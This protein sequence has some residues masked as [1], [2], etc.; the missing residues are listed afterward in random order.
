MHATTLFA[1]GLDWLEGL[2]PFLF[3]LFWIVSQVV[4]V[5]KG[6]AGRGKQPPVVARPAK[7]P[8]PQ[9]AGRDVRGE[10]ERQIEEFLKRAEPGQPRRGE[11]RPAAEA[12]RAPRSR[13]VA[14]PPA[15]PRAD[16]ATVA[17]SSR[18][19]P[20]PAQRGPAARDSDVSRHVKDAFS[21]QLKH[22]SSNLA[23][24]APQPLE[25]RP[26]AAPAAELVAMLRN[27]A[28]L[29]QLIL[30]REVLDRPTERW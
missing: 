29:K 10:L 23:R 8:V 22:L 30:L 24:E 3:L 12:V 4:N 11:R 16:V 28:T 20:K 5:I 21:S 6:G 26:A 25:P 27:P 17:G 2:L 9:P 14:S 18:L 19:Q 7:R 15:P 1:A 13:P